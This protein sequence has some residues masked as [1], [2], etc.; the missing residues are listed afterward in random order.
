MSKETLKN[1][2][3]ES[4]EVLLTQQET[5]EDRVLNLSLR[6]QRLEEFIGQPELVENL[7]VAIQ[8]AKQRSEPLEH[9]LLSGPQGLGKTTLAYIIAHEME[10]KI[11]ATSGPAIERAGDLIGILTNLAEGD[12][13]FIDEIHR[14]SKVVEEF[15]YPAMEQF[16]IDF[17]ID[18]G[19]YAKTIKFNLKRFTLVGATTRSGLLSSPLRARFGLNQHL[20]FYEDEDL[21]RI[22]ERSAGLLGISMEKEGA[23]EI[24][25]RSR[26][27][28][29]IANRLLRRVRDYAQVKGTGAVDRSVSEK[30]LEAQG[31]DVRGLDEL[32]RRVLRV[33]FQ[34]YS[35]G[36]VGLEAL[37][38][39]MNEEADTLVDVVEP[40]L[41]K[42]GFLRRTP[43]GREAT[44]S[45]REHLGMTPK[46]WL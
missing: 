24:A 16:Q 31:I 14:L 39:T 35:G 21:V 46:S 6:P 4:R 12:V 7:Q 38:A 44:L 23:Q 13:L 34:Q 26:G 10:T 9:L 27:T 40:F 32:D 28:P 45:A 1:Q 2:E 3:P 18:K 41:L 20:N 22:L 33:I 8:A 11:T 29:R 25:R 43:R 19:P 36:P 30:A 42:A 15:L 17:V 37:A 5:D